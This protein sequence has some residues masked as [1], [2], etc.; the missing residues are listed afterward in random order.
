[1]AMGF[2]DEKKSNWI[3]I[4]SKNTKDY[5]SLY[6]AANID[7]IAFISLWELGLL[8]TSTYAWMAT[9]CIEKYCKSLLLKNDSTIN[10]YAYNH[11]I[12]KVWDDCKGYLKLTE[13]DIMV[14]D[15]FIK[16][17]NAIQP[18]IRYGQQATFVSSGFPAIVI[19][20]GAIIRKEIIGDEEY[21]NNYGI[22]PS[23]FIV[24]PGTKEIEQELK[25]KKILHLVLEHSIT[26]SGLSIPDTL[27][28]AGINIKITNLQNHDTFKT[29]PWCNGYQKIGQV[30]TFELRNFLENTDQ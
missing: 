5:Y 1:M 18:S 27:G 13:K 16:E 24:R 25:I 29:C 6:F 30:A 22:L 4:E 17:L 7:Y 28:W 10:I 23:L 20:L 11:N 8:V 2:S 19:I 14:L 26:F 15:E 12:E 3:A 21:S 9:H